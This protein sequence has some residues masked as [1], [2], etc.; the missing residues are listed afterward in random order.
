MPDSDEH[1]V[2]VIPNSRW[3]I[4]SAFGLAMTVPLVFGCSRS[5]AMT[6][7]EEAAPPTQRL[8][9]PVVESIFDGGFS[10]KWKDL[11]WAPRKVTPGRPASIDMSHHGGWILARSD[12][13]GTFSGLAFKYRAPKS[14][15]N[16]LEVRVDSVREEVFP[17]VQVAE[18]HR[19][20][21]AD[22]WSDVWISMDE[23]DPKGGPFDRVILRAH[24]SVGSQPVEFDEIGLTG[25]TAPAAVV[26]AAAL[27]TVGPGGVAEMKIDCRSPAHKIQPMIYGIAFDPRLDKTDTHQWQLGAT[28]R[29]W[30][31]NPSS[32]FNWE[33][34]HAWNAGEDW[35]FR[36]VDYGNPSSTVYE[37][38]LDDDI[39]HGVKSAL[40]V[41]MLGW[42]AKD[43]QAYSFPVS[44]Y[45]DQRSVDTYRGDAG[46]GFRKDGTPITPGPP[47]KTSVA[48]PPSSIGRWVTAIRDR[49]AAK[50]RRS[51]QMYILDNEPM[52]WSS[53]HRDVHPQP[54]SYDELLAR[55]VAYGTAVRQADPDAV[56][57]GPA[58]WGWPAY[59]F[60][61]VD[62]A[63]GFR[64][65]PDR[66]AHGDMPLL[67]WYLKQLHEHERRTGVRLLDVVDVHFYPQ[68]VDHGQG[69][70]TNR[71]IA[72]RRIRS[73][74]G[75][76]DP[77][78]VDE[79]WIGE[80]VRL[81][82]RIREW[83]DEYYPGRGISIGEYRFGAEDQM[84]G[85]LAL[86]EA[87][88]RYGQLD[89][90]S[91]FY[92]TYPAKDSPAFWAFRAFGNFDSKGAR[93]LDWSVAASAPSTTSL[94]ASR[95]ESGDHVVAIALNL[96]PDH[97]AEAD[98]DFASCG[99]VSDGRIF[100]YT[101]GAA[102]LTQRG[103]VAAGPSSLRT[104]LPPYS[105]TVLDLRLARAHAQ[106]E[107]PVSQP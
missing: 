66:R 95:D 35:F 92:W 96:D 78:Y 40:T 102:G 100:G 36:N 65:R 5:H 50:K 19:V 72:A 18:M 11:G 105:I 98:V 46:D 12:L 33:I 25:E 38:F 75:L 88:G 79:S 81:I 45:G 107:T 14:F 82:P 56:I 61:A 86:A 71:E 8:R 21:H 7:A 2:V 42:V 94:F 76:W 16:F 85:A 47:T 49:D 48:A 83:I 74:R 15:G 44:E 26:P 67:A 23:L 84:A 41:P 22:G 55:T 77:S 91:A 53:T 10:P 20:D 70:G 37:S 64:L 60:S 1:A 57:A 13:S 97:P 29:R 69:G 17:R 93:F 31:G 6:P 63:A 3:G 54:V 103:T 87:L 24:R 27:G 106:A 30:G 4:A 90:T 51:V 52:L 80:P 28:A 34:G 32:R 62:A 68:S 59:F 39:S 43:T 99:N 104:T 73:T 58:L 89:L 9:A 101:G